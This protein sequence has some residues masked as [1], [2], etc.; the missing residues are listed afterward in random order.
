MPLWTVQ[1]DNSRIRF[2]AQQAGADFTGEWKNFTADIRFA[3]DNLENSSATVRMD[4]GGLAT[5]DNERDAILAGLD[6]FD[7][8]NFTSVVFTANH[9][10]TTATGFSTQA[11]LQLRG[12]SYPIE[13]NFTVTSNQG[14]HTLIGTS[15]LDRLALNLGTLEWLDTEWVGQFVD[16]EVQILGVTKG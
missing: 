16:V 3:T 14:T 12:A 10:Q 15:R 7:T 6:W 13:F 11:T 2:T 5:N 1:D 9:F 8:D 4:A